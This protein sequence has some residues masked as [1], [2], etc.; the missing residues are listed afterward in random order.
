MFFL[1]VKRIKE[2]LHRRFALSLRVEV[3][4]IPFSQFQLSCDEQVL[5]HPHHSPL[6][7]ES[8]KPSRSLRLWTLSLSKGVE[9]AA[10]SLPKGPATADAVGG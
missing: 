8:Q 4:N 2:I 7:G 10:L 5:T 3:A 1:I 6:E 9:G